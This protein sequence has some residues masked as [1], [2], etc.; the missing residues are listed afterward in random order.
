M[1]IILIRHGKPTSAKNPVVDASGYIKWVR[2]YHHSAVADHSRPETINDEYKSYYIVS[3]DLKRAIHSA[4][5]YLEKTPE[6][7]DKVFREME[8]PRYKFPFKLKAWSWLYLSRVLWMLGY[9]GPFESFKQAKQRADLA[10]NRLIEI[11]QNQTEEKVV[12]FGHGFINR[13]IRKSLIKK[14]WQLNAKSNAYWG[15]T[16]LK[17]QATTKNENMNKN[18]VNTQ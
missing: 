12:L 8:I 13:Y 15:V 10:T 6:T 1:E 4:N 3:S 7:V 9:I 5:I 16:R 11:A 17:L 18:K 2:Q 14:G